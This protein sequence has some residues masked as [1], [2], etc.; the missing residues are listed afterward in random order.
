VGSAAARALVATLLEVHSVGLGK[1]LGLLAGAGDPGRALATACAKDADVRGM[2]ALHEL[3][4]EVEVDAGDHA[5]GP[6]VQ[7]R[8]P[9]REQPRG[10][11]ASDA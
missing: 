2:L 7:L 3:E 6:L 8:V 11:G 9:R 5:E 10:G 4:A 1:V